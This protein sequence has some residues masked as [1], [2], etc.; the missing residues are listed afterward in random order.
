MIKLKIKIKNINNLVFMG[1]GVKEIGINAYMGS[2]SQRRIF[3]RRK[4]AEISVAKTQQ[5]NQAIN[6]FR[7]RL[8]CLKRKK[9]SFS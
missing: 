3:P 8:C 9:M 1:F 6:L 5:R 4:N 2:P 7:L